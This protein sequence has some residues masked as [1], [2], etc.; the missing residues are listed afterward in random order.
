MHVSLTS[1]YLGRTRLVSNFEFQNPSVQVKRTILFKQQRT[2]NIT[3]KHLP[4]TYF[5][6]IMHFISHLAY[7]SFS[8]CQ[9]V[10][11]SK[12]QTPDPQVVSREQQ[13]P[14]KY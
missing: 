13:L 10:L 2:A 4:V 11:S 8:S 12:L 7:S 5:T 1:T 6:Q 14:F 9:P 3:V